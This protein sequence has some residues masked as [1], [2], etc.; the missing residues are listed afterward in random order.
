MATKFTFNPPT[1]L[2]DVSVYPTAPTSEAA[3]REQIQRG[4]DQ[5]QTFLNDVVVEDLN[6]KPSTS[7]DFTN[8]L[9]AN[10]Y[11]KLPGGLILQWGN[12][13]VSLNNETR[14]GIDFNFPIAFKSNVFSVTTN[15]NATTMKTAC[16]VFSKNLTS[17]TAYINAT[18]GVATTLAPHNVNWIAIGV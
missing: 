2:N 13:P 17:A 15:I 1:G 8:S 14:K 11:V 6:D 7:K 16:N 3:A 4:M 9:S 10:G 12:V 5:L 18:D